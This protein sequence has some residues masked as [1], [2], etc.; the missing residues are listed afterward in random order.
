MLHRSRAILLACAMASVCVGLPG[1]TPTPETAVRGAF[2]AGEQALV[3][4][5]LEAAAQAFR[6]VLAW[7]PADVGAHTNLGVVYMRQQ[8]WKL[9]IAELRAAEKLAPGVSGIRLNIGLAYYRQGLYRE[10]V[11]PFEFVIREQ[12]QSAQARRLLGLCYFFTERPAEAADELDGLWADSKSDL[13]YLYVLALAAG[14]AHRTELEQRALAQMLVV[15]QNT[16]EYH[17]FL[18]KAYLNRQDDNAALAELEQ[19]ARV[20]PKL[21]FVHY[22]LGVVYRRKREFDKAKQEFLADAHIEPDVAYNYDQLGIVSQMAGDDPTAQR[23]YLEAV[24][25]DAQLGT[26]WYGL[27]K[28]YSKQKKYAEALHA[29]EAAGAID[30]NSASVHY[31]RGQILTQLGRKEQARA[32]MATVR[33][34]NQETRDKLEQQV[35]GSGYRDPQLAQP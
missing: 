7:A 17:L 16:A 1:Q 24:K 23:Y 31:L 33:R 4:G 12:P 11:A 26:S 27:G 35:T 6:K 29:L 21:P 8:K 32:E 19:A 22:N 20:N 28:I 5:D 34:L 15:G 14:A 18:G 25:L 13:T 9:A 10:A 3:R 2:E 30:P